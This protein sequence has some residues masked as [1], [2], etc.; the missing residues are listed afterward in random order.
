MVCSLPKCHYILKLKCV[1]G[2]SVCFNVNASRMD[3]N[4]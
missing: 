1:S 4:I 3:F 2:L